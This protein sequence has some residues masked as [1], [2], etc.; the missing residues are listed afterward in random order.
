MFLVRSLVLKERISFIVTQKALQIV[1]NE[2]KGNRNT[3]SRHKIYFFFPFSCNFGDWPLNVSF[4]R[5]RLRWG[6]A[7]RAGA[8]QPRGEK[9]P[10]R[11]YIS[12]PV[13]EGAYRKDG[14]GLII[15]EYSGRTRGNSFKLKEDRFRLDIRKTFFF[16]L[17]WGGWGT[18]TGCPERLWLPLPWQC[19]RPGWMGLWATWSG[20]RC[21]CPWQGGWN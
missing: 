12:L 5:N 17:Q 20:G 21:P 9:A 2:T 4:I 1:N 8:V 10:G 16:F 11:F 7:E 18:G 19:S 6:Q 14:E 15:R 3:T 13:H